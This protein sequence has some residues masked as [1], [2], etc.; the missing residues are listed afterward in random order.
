MGLAKLKI[1]PLKNDFNTRNE[2]GAV[3]V[4][5][6]PKELTLDSSTQFQRSAMPGL[7]AP[8]TQFVSGQA[9]TMSLS[10]FF[11][12]YEKKTDVREETKKLT[13]LLKIDPKIHAPP[14][15]MFEWGGPLS[16][17]PGQMFKGVFDKISQKF[18]MFLDSGIPVRATLTVNI[19]EFQ[20]ILEQKKFIKF[21]SSD[22]TKIRI[23]TQGDQ[24][25][26][27]STK[28][29]DDKTLWRVIATA[30]DIE[31]PRLLT[32]GREVILPPLEKG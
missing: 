15:C 19:S 11:D 14:V 20:T 3:T 29:Y 22:R 12:T 32:A 27:L 25:W 9:Q 8:V 28:E 4:M 18:T 24:L 16:A 17:E 30:N 1:I 13:N 26:H 31:N 5:Y 10:L 2:A 6:N 21:Q 7:Q 23:I